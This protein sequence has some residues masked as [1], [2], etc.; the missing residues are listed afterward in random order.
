MDIKSALYPSIQARLEQAVAVAFL[1]TDRLNRECED[2][3]AKNGRLTTEVERLREENQALRASAEIW[4][5][6]YENQLSR[7]NRAAEL[8]AHCAGTVTR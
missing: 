4:I 8:L 6:M 2:L 7:A 1:E 3:S 5:R